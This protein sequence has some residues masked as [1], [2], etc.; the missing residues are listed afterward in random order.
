MKLNFSMIVFTAAYL[1]AIGCSPGDSLSPAA[2]QALRDSADFELLSLDPDPG[3]TEGNGLCG[4][5]VLG[6]TTIKDATV[7]AKLISAFK[8]GVAESDDTAV[9][10]FRPRHGI[11][12]VHEGTTHEF[13]ICFQCYQVE[14]YTNSDNTGGFHIAGSPQPTFDEI[15]K[16]SNVPV[17]KKAND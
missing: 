10:C 5:N 12:V 2:E 15:L 14:W 1:V 16:A 13:V 7:R 9:N 4:W 3:K 17:A 6:K 8:A 11:K